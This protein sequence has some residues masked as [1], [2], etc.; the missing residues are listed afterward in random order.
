MI[1]LGFAKMQCFTAVSC[2]LLVLFVLVNILI[3]NAINA[4]MVVWIGDNILDFA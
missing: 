2:V 3:Y 4:F 1:R